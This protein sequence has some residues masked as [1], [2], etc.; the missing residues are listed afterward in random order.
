MAE[1]LRLRFGGV[2]WF[3]AGAVLVL[4]AIAP[5]SAADESQRSFKAEVLFRLANPCPGTGQTHGP[6]K[7]YVIDRVIPLV[8][9]GAEAPSNM[10]WQTIAEAKEKDRWEK[11]G[12]RPGRTLVLPGPPSPAEA[13]PLQEP[14]TPAEVQPLPIE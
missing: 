1:L 2:D 9:G 7:G 14:A 3:A 5:A 8:C 12:C 4:A 11:I 10:Q 6:C 13:Y